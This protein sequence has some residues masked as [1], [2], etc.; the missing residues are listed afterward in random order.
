M[1]FCAYLLSFSPFLFFLS[2]HRFVQNQ[3]GAL[4]H[5][6]PSHTGDSSTFAK[7]ELGGWA[8]AVAAEARQARKVSL[9]FAAAARKNAIGWANC[10]R[11][12]MVKLQG[13]PHA[14][15]KISSQRRRNRR[16]LLSKRKDYAPKHIIK[17][18]S[19]AVKSL[20][21]A[22]AHGFSF[23]RQIA[24]AT[25]ATS[26]TNS[27]FTSKNAVRN[28]ILDA[29]LPKKQRHG[30]RQLRFAENAFADHMRAS[31]ICPLMCGDTP[32]SR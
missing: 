16:R 27:T 15:I 3:G 31:A 18:A 25:A 1:F 14:V 12:E 5:D 19:A 10:S 32:T 28:S 8:S 13:F 6:Q 17:S 4:K 21:T 11:K 23:T 22:A 26:L 30:R 24:G 9:Y 2:P 7:D 29:Q 20:T